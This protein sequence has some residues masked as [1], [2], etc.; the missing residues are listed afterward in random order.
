[1]TAPTGPRANLAERLRARRWRMTPQ[2]RAVAAAFVGEHVH[3]TAEEIHD[4]A[5]RI[6]TE[7]SLATIYN[8]LNELVRMGELIE[9]RTSGAA[10]R[11]DPNVGDQHGHL[12]CTGCGRMLDVNPAGVAALSLPGSDQHGFRITGV[13]VL[14]RGTCP[15]CAAR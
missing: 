3:L 9:V 14:F 12:V 8:T 2:R 4:R 13:D 10:V 1:M 6:A 15:D 5:R 7:V 11:Y